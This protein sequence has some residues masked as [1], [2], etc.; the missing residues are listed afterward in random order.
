[1]NTTTPFDRGNLIRSRSQEVMKMFYRKAIR[2]L[3]LFV[4][5]MFMAPGI[6]PRYLLAQRG[7]RVQ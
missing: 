6:I 7:R 2:L 3:P 5:A 4:A 1:M